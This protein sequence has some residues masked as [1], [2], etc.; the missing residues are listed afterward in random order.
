MEMNVGSRFEAR[1][2]ALTAQG[3]GVC[4]HPSGGA[5]FVP[6]TWPGDRGLLEVT[7]LDRRYSHARLVTLLDPSPARVAVPCPHQGLGEGDCG[8][9]PWMF[10]AY[11]AQL[12]EKVRSVRYQLARAGFST[13]TTAIHPIKGSEAVFGYRNRAQ[14][15]TDGRVIGYVS[16]K[17]RTIAPVS[18]CLV[19]DGATRALFHRLK[20]QLPNDAWL[21]GEGFDWNYLDID[22]DTMLETLEVNRRR[23][24]KQGNEGQNRFMAA[25]LAARLEP[26]ARSAPL[27]ELF[28][29]SGNFTDGLSALG[30]TTICASEVAKK[31][32]ETLA[33]RNLPG[34]TAVAADLF[35]PGVWN[36]LK[37][38]MRAPEILVLDPP[39]AGFQHLPRFLREFPSI[40]TILYVSCDLPN[41]TR[42]AAQARK[43]GFALTEVQPLDLFPH[44]PH[45]EL[46]GV[47]R[48]TTPPAARG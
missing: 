34:V 3:V 6:G 8:G 31:A 28:A 33:A 2:R 40:R 18:D 22:G 10:A 17:S 12:D 5:F 1:V 13:E 15:K 20:D 25:W 45:V 32:V 43:K 24:F 47:F 41:F 36:L 37:K 9:C 26:E 11:G 48:K 4:D 29:G 14:F 35:K 7:A 44:T 19:L 16:Q 38:A 46:L 27:L 21:P 42:D 39:R 23:P 30:F